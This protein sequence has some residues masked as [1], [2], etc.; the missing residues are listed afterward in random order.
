MNKLEK[1]FSYNVKFLYDGAKFVYKYIPKVG[2]VLNNNS[3]KLLVET[4]FAQQLEWLT[5]NGNPTTTSIV[6]DV[7]MIPGVEINIYNQQIINGNFKY[8][9]FARVGTIGRGGCKGFFLYS[10][11]TIQGFANSTIP[12]INYNGV[13]NETLAY[14]D[15]EKYAFAARTGN[16]ICEP[17]SMLFNIIAPKDR[18]EEGKADIPLINE[19]ILQAA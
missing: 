16:L 18:Q 19:N 12:L 15:K 6:R 13:F 2:E 8:D 3:I 10:A 5:K 17:Y 14:I 11:D 9:E 7:L 1:M 4:L